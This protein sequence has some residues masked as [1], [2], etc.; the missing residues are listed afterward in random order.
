VVVT[1]CPALLVQV[2]GRGAKQHR[3]AVWVVGVI[4]VLY[5]VPFIIFILAGGMTVY[6]A[7][8]MVM[9]LHLAVLIVTAKIC[10]CF[11]TFSKRRE[12]A[13][14]V[15]VKDATAAGAGYTSHIV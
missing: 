15:G 3:A 12:A 4:A 14:M 5:P 1:A 8:V 9:H 10:S 2:E 11:Q 6:L 13:A 7:V